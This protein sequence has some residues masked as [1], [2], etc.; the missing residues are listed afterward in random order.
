[1]QSNSIYKLYNKNISLLTDLYQL[2]MANAYWKTGVH[3]REAVFHLTY[4][5]NPFKGDYAIACGRDLVIDWLQNL[6]FSQNESPYIE[7]MRARTRNQLE[8]FSK[9]DFDEYPIGLEENLYQKKQELI[10][11]FQTVTS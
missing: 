5:T 3:R 11:Q 10:G 1:M 7:A 4:R 8:L 9:V 6:R 2:T